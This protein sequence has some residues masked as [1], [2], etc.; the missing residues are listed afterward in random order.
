M[1]RLWKVYGLLKATDLTPK[2]VLNRV[3]GMERKVKDGRKQRIHRDV[4]EGY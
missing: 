2:E 4:P 1:S 3:V